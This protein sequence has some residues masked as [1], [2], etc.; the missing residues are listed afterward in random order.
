MNLIG[1]AAINEHDRRKILDLLGN[2]ASQY[3]LKVYEKGFS[4]KK[5]SVDTPKIVAFL[6]CL[7][8]FIDHSIEQ[9]RLPGSPLQCLA[10]KVLGFGA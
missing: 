5:T 7:L 9:N 2:V 1:G 8:K 3:R 10:G 6:E 4:G